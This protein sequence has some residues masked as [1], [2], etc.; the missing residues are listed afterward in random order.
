MSA[1]CNSKL[2]IY[3]SDNFNAWIPHCTSSPSWKFNISSLKMCFKVEIIL[4]LYS[5]IFLNLQKKGVRWKNDAQE[6][7]TCT[8]VSTEELVTI[9]PIFQHTELF[10][11]FETIHLKMIVDV[12][13]FFSFAFTM[14]WWDSSS[15]SVKTITSRTLLTL[16]PSKRMAVQRIWKKSMNRNYDVDLQKFPSINVLNSCKKKGFHFCRWAYIKQV[17]TLRIYWMCEHT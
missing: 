2:K 16:L 9:V 15:Y 8:T 6:L 12:I 5:F 1:N 3:A 10:E 13:P 7:Y 14:C 17:V 4:L 11:L